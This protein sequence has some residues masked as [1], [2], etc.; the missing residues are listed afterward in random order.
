M[1]S[2]QLSKLLIENDEF[3]KEIKSMKKSINELQ[4]KIDK[5]LLKMDENKTR[6][7]EITKKKL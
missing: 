5:L 6:I 3:R 4:K 1:N 7:L 2:K